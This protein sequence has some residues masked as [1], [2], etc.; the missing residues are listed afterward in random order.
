MTTKPAVVVLITTEQVP[1]VVVHVLAPAGTKT[2][3]AVLVGRLNVTTV[4]SGTGPK[5]VTPSPPWAPAARPSSWETV[6][7]IVWELRT[8]LTAVSG[9]TLILPSTYV[10]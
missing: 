10:L 9:V 8:S 7:V 2:A 1:P 4:P 3:L 5:P 6:A